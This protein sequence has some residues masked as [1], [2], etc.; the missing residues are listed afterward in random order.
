MYYH[1][2]VTLKTEDETELNAFIQQVKTKAQNQGKLAL[3][4][5][6]NKMKYQDKDGIWI[7]FA[8]AW[9]DVTLSDER[10]Q[11]FNKFKNFVINNGG[12][13]DWHECSHDEGINKP[14]IV[15][16]SFDG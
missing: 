3:I 15:S 12:S 7:L 13:V 1:I 14:C 4:K 2:R 8:E 11:I 5:K 10:I 9:L 6:F 16:E